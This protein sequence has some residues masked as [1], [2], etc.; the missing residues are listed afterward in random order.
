MKSLAPIDFRLLLYLPRNAKFVGA[1][2]EGILQIKPWKGKGMSTAGEGGFK[3][4]LILQPALG[5]THLCARLFLSIIFEG[6]PK[7]SYDLYSS[8]THNF[9]NGNENVNGRL[10]GL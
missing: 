5:M 2:K 4:F 1:G 9:R 10:Y 6:G 7:I 8:I 3:S